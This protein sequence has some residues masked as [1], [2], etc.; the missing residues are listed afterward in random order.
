MPARRHTTRSREV[1]QAIKKIPME[2]LRPGMF[3]SNLNA[4]WIKR[5]YRSGTAR[6]MSIAAEAQIGAILMS[7]IQ[8]VHLDTQRGLDAPNAPTAAKAP[9][10]TEAEIRK[11]ADERLVGYEGSSAWG[12]DLSRFNG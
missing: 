10:V 12:I 1:W 7:G 3:A 9:A 2:Q 5:S 6:Q 8:E 4:I 11:T